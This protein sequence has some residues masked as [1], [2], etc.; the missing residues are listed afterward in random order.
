M[1]FV[2]V[3][4]FIKVADYSG[5]MLVNIIPLLVF[6]LFNYLSFFVIFMHYLKVYRKK[7]T[8]YRGLG[9]SDLNLTVFIICE[10]LLIIIISLVFGFIM[11]SIFNNALEMK[12]YLEE[13]S[14]G[15]VYGFTVLSVVA[16]VIISTVILL[17]EVL[18]DSKR[19]YG[20]RNKYE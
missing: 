14:I 18:I 17:I 15:K 10:M 13:C 2:S 12:V 6:T 7:I 20:K 8:I 3:A 9:I 19:S 5:D 4:L 16:I 1:E 11:D